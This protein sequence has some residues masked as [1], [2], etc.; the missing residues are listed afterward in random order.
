MLIIPAIDLKGG[1]VVRLLRGDFGV[2]T[3][4]GDPLETLRAFASAGAAWVHIVD[5][6]GAKTGAPV[7]HDLVARLVAETGLSVQTGGG[8]RTLEHV[9]TLLRVGVK[10]VVAGSVAVRDPESVRGWIEQVGIESICVAFDVRRVADDWEV[11]SEGWTA[12][13][14]TTLSDALAAFPAGSL[15]HVLVTDISRDGALTGSNVELVGALARL[16]PDISFQASGGVASLDD[17]EAQRA[18]GAGAIIIGRALYERRF[19]LE[20]A[21]AV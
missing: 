2:V 17:L 3:E 19:T 11:A 5:L 21:L 6:D 1:V 7:Q 8:V 16:R 9:T 20:A 14:G 4:Y 12:S 18:A 10:R 13:G 15:R